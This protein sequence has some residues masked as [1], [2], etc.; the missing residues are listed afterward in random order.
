LIKTR[1]E[2]FERIRAAIKE[3]HS[4]E[5]PECVMLDVAAGSHEYLAWITEN[6]T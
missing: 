1:A 6:T 3:L 4:Y 5:L 2:S